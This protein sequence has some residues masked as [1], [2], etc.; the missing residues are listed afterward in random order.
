MRASA[1][2]S[3]FRIALALAALAVIPHASAAADTSPNYSQQSIVH[4]ATQTVEALA[5]NTIATI[6]G[7]NLSYTTHALSAAD[8][9]HS[10]LPTTLE[11]VSVYVNGI[12]ANLFYV[13]PLQINFLVPYELTAGTVTVLVVRQGISGLPVKIQ[14]K[15]TAPGFFPFDGTYAIGVHLDGSL[16]SAA[17]PAKGGEIIIL[18]A[19]GLGRTSPD[20]VSG[21]VVSAAAVIQANAQLQILLDNAPIPAANVLYAGLAPGFAGLYQINLRLPDMLSPNPEIRIAIGTQ[22]SPPQIHLAVN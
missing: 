20:T 3:V 7:T 14:L 16:V 12:L 13:S 10:V 21:K 8:L 11:G 2:L 5:P 6:Y 4:A 19:A 17:S 9:N 1:P 15:A 18:Y 22:M